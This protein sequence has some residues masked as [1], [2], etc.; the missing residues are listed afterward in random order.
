MNLW[1]DFLTNRGKPIGKWV[2]YF[3]VYERHLAA[4]RNQ[5]LFVL[6]IGVAGGGSGQMWSRFFGPR[7]QVVG[8]DI[9]PA[10][11]AHEGLGVAVRIGSQSDPAF[12]SRIL[13]EF[14]V[15]DVVIDDGSHR[16]TDILATFQRIFP[17]MPKNSVYIVE[18]LHTAY[19]KSYGGG[20]DNPGTFINV[21]KHFVDQINAFWGKE[22]GMTPDLIT[23]DVFGIS[24]YDSMVVIEKGGVKWREAPVIGEGF[25]NPL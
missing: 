19:W 3:S 16:M 5:S 23:Q 8:I 21:C 4:K 15:P 2:H 17:L 7:T 24:F 25:N 20:R 14:G 13:D 9:D 18:D 22:D 10:C 11:A 1:Q 12:L 6:E